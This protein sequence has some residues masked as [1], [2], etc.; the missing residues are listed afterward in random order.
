M[1][2]D[3]VKYGT[4]HKINELGR[5]TAGKTGTTNNFLDALYFG[6]VPDLV[7]GVWVGYDDMHPL[8]QSESG[9]KAAGP[10]WLSF[11]KEVTLDWEKKPFVAP[12]GVIF[13]KVD[14]ETGLLPSAGSESTYLECFKKG[15]EPREYAPVKNAEEVDFF[16]MDSRSIGSLP[17]RSP[18]RPSESDLL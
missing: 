16:E 6:F 1:L 11:M 5:P 8:G 14:A 2:E 10:I 13:V 4:G 7:A 12:P 9:S 15:S 18:S 17:E 3:V